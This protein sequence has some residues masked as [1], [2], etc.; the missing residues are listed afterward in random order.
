VAAAIEEG[1]ASQAHA[2]AEAEA[3]A[4]VDGKPASW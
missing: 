3:E 4:D 1:P 2:A